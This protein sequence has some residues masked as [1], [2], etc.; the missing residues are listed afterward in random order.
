[1]RIAYCV[2]KA[3]KTHVGCVILIAFPLQQWLQER[4]SMLL[5]NIHCLSYFNPSRKNSMLHCKLN[6]L[7]VD[8]SFYLFSTV[9][10]PEVH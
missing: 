4:V 7:Q 1:M 10:K 2:P 6:A 9:I 3:T 8:I 5:Y